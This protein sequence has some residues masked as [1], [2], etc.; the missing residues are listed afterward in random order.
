VA[1]TGVERSLGDVITKEEKTS[2]DV[3]SHDMERSKRGEKNQHQQVGERSWQNAEGTAYK[4]SLQI[5]GVLAQQLRGDKVSAKY[6]KVCT[7]C[8]PRLNCPWPEKAA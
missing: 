4:E 2:P 7:S 6:K 3:V 5:D 8:W 1:G